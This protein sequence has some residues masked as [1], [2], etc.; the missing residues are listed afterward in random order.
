MTEFSGSEKKAVRASHECPT[1]LDKTAMDGAPGS[2]QGDGFVLVNLGDGCRER[3][4]FG[5]NVLRLLVSQVGGARKDEAARGL[6]RNLARAADV[7]IQT[8]GCVWNT[9]RVRCG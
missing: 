7:M 8:S 4:V 2:I 1:D 6:L 9:R 3:H 5:P